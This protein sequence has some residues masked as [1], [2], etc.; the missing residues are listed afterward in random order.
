MISSDGSV[1][2]SSLRTRW[3]GD[4]GLEPFV[5]PTGT[6]GAGVV[7]KSKAQAKVRATT[8]QRRRT[9]IMCVSLP[10]GSAEHQHLAA[11]ELVGIG[12]RIDRGNPLLQCLLG[13]AELF[14]GVAVLF[15][16]G[17]LIVTIDEPA[18]AEEDRDAAELRFHLRG[19]GGDEAAET[20]A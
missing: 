3:A 7:V 14:V 1:R 18:A 11:L 5:S 13:A 4:S 10:I 16:E 12:D 8:G 19:Q 20:G 9:A 17:M 15:G 6:A 2:S